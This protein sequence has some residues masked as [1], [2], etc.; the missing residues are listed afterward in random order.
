MMEYKFISFISFSNKPFAHMA[1]YE[2]D[3][4]KNIPKDYSQLCEF[5]EENKSMIIGNNSLLRSILSILDD[6]LSNAEI[7]R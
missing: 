6:L 5:I 4:F 1:Q 7:M 3:E 2:I